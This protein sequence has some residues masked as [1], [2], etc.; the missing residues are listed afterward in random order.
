MYA[1]SNSFVFS[2]LMKTMLFLGVLL[3]LSCSSAI[4]EPFWEIQDPSLPFIAMVRADP[5]SG[6]VVIYNPNYCEQIGDACGFFRAHEYAH[7]R[8]N[9]PLVAPVSYPA[10]MEKQADCFAAKFGKPNEIY[11]AVQFLR[12]VDTTALEWRIYGDPAQRAETI[13]RCAI[14]A[15]RWIGNE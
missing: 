1:T 2:K 12:K 15:G 9:H 13:R 4:I 6:S 8:L 14:E 5:Q 10:S 11:A 7:V 3:C